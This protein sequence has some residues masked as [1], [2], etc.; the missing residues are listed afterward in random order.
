MIKIFNQGAPI[1]SCISEVLISNDLIALEIN[2]I[3][4]NCEVVATSGRTVFIG[5]QPESLYLHGDD[6]K[7]MTEVVLDRDGFEFFAASSDRSNIRIVFMRT[8]FLHP[9][10]GSTGLLRQQ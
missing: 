10:R 1:I 5:C 2:L 3:T 7:A 8:A 4:S 6:P 9:R